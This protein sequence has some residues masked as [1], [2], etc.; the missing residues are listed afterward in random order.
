M[1]L[2]QVVKSARVMKKAVAYLM[3]YM[4][5][6]KEAGG[7]VRSQGKILLA[8]V[9]GDVHDIGKNIVGVVLGCNNYEVIDLGVMVPVSKILDTAKSQNVDIIGLSGLITPSLDEMAHVAGEMQRNEFKLPLLIGGATTSKAHTAVKIAP[10]YEKPVVHVLDASRAVGVVS[11][12]LNQEQREEFLSRNAADQE[13]LRQEFSSRQGSRTLLPI[14][15]ARRRRTPIE[16]KSDDIAVPM[17][18]GV[19]LLREVPLQ[20]IVPYID[21]S[22]FF[23]TW[24]LRGRYPNIFEDKTYGPQAK[25]LFKDAQDVLRRILDEKLLTANAVYGLFPANAVGD[26]VELYT[27][28]SRREMLT[29]FHFLRQQMDKPAGQPNQALSDFIA[30]KQTEIPDYIGGFAVS[31]G[32]GL[33][34]IVQEYEANHDSYSAILAKALADRFAEALA[35]KLHQQVRNVWQYGKN[36]NLTNEELINE[37]YRGIRPAA[38]YPACPDHTEKRILFDLLNVENSTGIF[39]TE[40]MAMYPGASVSGLYFAHPTAKYFPVGK[41]NP[42]Q[43]EDYAARKGMDLAEV[44]R[45]LSPNLNYDPRKAARAK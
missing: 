41:I 31:A 9:K 13:A 12:L 24:E 23:H 35:E 38:G 45:W 17:Q 33:E 26:D 40:S 10:E 14:E 25:E 16:W 4:E 34:K 22:P 44:E 21:W 3:P 11:A 43:V 39:L 8:T 30:P 2:P 27:N 6:E 1:F 36:E 19:T 29:T 7:G 37:R 42:D 32:F 5:A 20:E 18:L 28:E 15:E